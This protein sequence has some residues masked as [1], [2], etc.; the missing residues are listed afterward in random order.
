MYDFLYLIKRRNFSYQCIISPKMNYYQYLNKLRNFIIGL[1]LIRELGFTSFTSNFNKIISYKKITKT[2]TKKLNFH[3]NL[4]VFRSSLLSTKNL[5]LNICSI[6]MFSD[7][8]NPKY[9]KKIFSLIFFKLLYNIHTV[10]WIQ[11]FK[12][13]QYTQYSILF[14]MYSHQVEI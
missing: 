2:T 6:Q 5:D 13:S 10:P 1:Y 12:N 14:L 4:V 11:N 7:F 8:P 3:P 9:R